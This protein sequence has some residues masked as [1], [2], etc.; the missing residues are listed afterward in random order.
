MVRRLF[1]SLKLVFSN[2]IIFYMYTFVSEINY[3]KNKGYVPKKFIQTIP[4]APAV[5]PAFENIKGI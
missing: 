3:G 4:T 1:I 2:S 5:I